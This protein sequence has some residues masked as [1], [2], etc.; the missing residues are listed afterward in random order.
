MKIDDFCLYFRLK[1]FAKI[2]GFVKILYSA[3]IMRMFQ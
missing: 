2:N 1:Y 3:Y